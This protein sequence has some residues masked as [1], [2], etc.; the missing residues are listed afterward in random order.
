M[1]TYFDITWEYLE[2]KRSSSWYTK[3]LRG[4][5]VNVCGGRISEEES[6]VLPISDIQKAAVERMK[7]DILELLVGSEKF[8]DRLDRA[9]DYQRKAVIGQ[10]YHEIPDFH[11]YKD[12]RPFLEDYLVSGMIK[13]SGRIEVIRA[14]REVQKAVKEG[15]RCYQCRQISKD[16]YRLGTYEG[17][18]RGFCAPCFRRRFPKTTHKKKKR[19]K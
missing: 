6:Q 7:A 12:V 8:T 9:N 5:V 19:K 1:E 14:Q 18:I 16:F 17:T 10:F 3:R 11:W 2:K 15:L 13:P 4:W